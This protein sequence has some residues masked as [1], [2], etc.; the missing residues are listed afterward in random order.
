[1]RQPGY[2]LVGFWFGQKNRNRGTGCGSPARPDL[3]GGHRVTG[4]FTRK[5]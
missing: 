1:M 3:W 4:A 2:C 5:N